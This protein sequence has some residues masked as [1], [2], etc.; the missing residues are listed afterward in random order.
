MVNKYNCKECGNSLPQDLI[1]YL[2]DGNQVFCERCGSPFTLAN[3]KIKKGKEIKETLISPD[4]IIRGQK[5]L[6]GI[7]LLNLF[8][9]IYFFLFLTILFN[10]FTLFKLLIFIRI[11]LP[12]KYVGVIIFIFI[13]VIGFLEISRGCKLFMKKEYKSQI[14]MVNTIGQDLLRKVLYPPSTEENI[15]SNDNEVEALK[16]LIPFMY[17]NFF[18]ANFYY[19]LPFNFMSFIFEISIFLFI[20]IIVYIIHLCIG[21]IILLKTKRLRYR[22][23]RT[24]SIVQLIFYNFIIALTIFNPRSNFIFIILLDISLFYLSIRIAKNRDVLM[25]FL[26]PKYRVCHKCGILIKKNIKTCPKCVEDFSKKKIGSEEIPVKKIEKP[27]SSYTNL[28]VTEVFIAKRSE[29]EENPEG[30]QYSENLSFVIEEKD[31][32]LLEKYLLKR[33]VVVPERLRKFIDKLN[34]LG[35]DKIDLL[36]DFSFLASKEQGNLLELLIH[37]FND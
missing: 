14:L 36:K 29:P 35:K 23:L 19:S 34:L 11:T 17:V 30:L 6:I 28:P 20:Y 8:L 3:D 1:A 25:Q 5:I 7:I 24:S 16:I 12:L 21:F 4:N 2:E 27:I 33:F 26:P 18:L 9:V 10:P 22:F 31:K 15:K 37:L 13:M 32:E